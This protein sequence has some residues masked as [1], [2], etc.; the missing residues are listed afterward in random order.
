MHQV[1]GHV[2]HGHVPRRSIEQ[3]VENIFACRRITRADQQ[4]FMNAL[5]SKDFLNETEK[6]QINRVF[7]GLRTGVLRVAD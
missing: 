2:P 3:V 4:Q 6:I 1:R 7:D 5:L